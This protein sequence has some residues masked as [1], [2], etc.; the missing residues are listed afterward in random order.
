M[1]NSLK[2]YFICQA[3]F[4][5]IGLIVLLANLIINMDFK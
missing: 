3:I 2:V 4:H 5:C 1:N